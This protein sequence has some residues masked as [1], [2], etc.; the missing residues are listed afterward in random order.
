MSFRPAALTTYT[1]IARIPTRFQR[2]GGC[3]RIVAPDGSETVPTSKP[4]PDVMLVKAPPLPVLTAVVACPHARHS[5]RL[6]TA[7]IGHMV[8]EQSPTITRFMPGKPISA[9]R[10][11]AKALPTSGSSSVA[12]VSVTD[13]ASSRAERQVPDTLQNLGRLQMSIYRYLSKA[14]AL[15]VA[16][17][18]FV[19]SLPIGA[20]RAGLVATEQVVEERAASS[21]RERLVAILLRDD[22]RQQMEALGVDRHEAIA[23]LASLSD[24]EIQQIAGRI[25]E[26]PA[27]QSVLVGVLVVA[28]V[29]LIALVITDLLG[30]TD[31][32]AVINPVR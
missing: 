25:D 12:S 27:G 31:V 1:L 13:V 30:V 16:A 14:V 32:F 21:D 19:T 6:K 29:V 24:Q 20:A 2:R 15:A 5:S 4:E 3:K 11:L 8:E 9:K 26:L 7:V 17:A 22:V 10:P 28:G 23:R 18:L